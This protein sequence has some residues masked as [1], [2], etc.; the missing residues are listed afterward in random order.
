MHFVKLLKS[1]YAIQHL[2]LADMEVQI[3]RK[4]IICGQF[5]CVSSNWSYFLNILRITALLFNP[6]FHYVNQ[7]LNIFKRITPMAFLFRAANHLSKSDC[8]FHHITSFSS[9]PKASTVI[10]R[11]STLWFLGYAYG[12]HHPAPS[13]CPYSNPQNLYITFPCIRTLLLNW[14]SWDEIIILDYPGGSNVVTRVCIRES[15]KDK[16][17]KRRIGWWDQSLQW[18]TLYTEEKANCQGMQEL[19]HKLSFEASSRNEDQV[20]PGF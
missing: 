10:S 2:S 12:R 18:C 1:F 20:T 3:Q 19:L 4:I 7:A 5:H 15:N 16:I 11:L 9:S 13:R 8:V 6:H 14:E 17:R